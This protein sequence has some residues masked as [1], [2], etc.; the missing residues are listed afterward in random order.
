MR[1]RARPAFTLIELLVV[2]VI[3]A[4]LIGLLL[5]AV[6]KVRD[7]AARASCQN[8]LKQL[9]LAMHNYHDAAGT[10]PTGGD[11]KPTPTKYL[12][13]WVPLLMPFIEDDN[14]RKAIDAMGS[15]ADLQPWRSQIV[16]VMTSPVF[17]TP[18]KTLVC[19]S[20]ELIASSDSFPDD[21]VA[22]PTNHLN[23]SPLH[24]RANGGSATLG[25]QYATTGRHQWWA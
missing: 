21:V 14:R 5:P 19:P 20:S 12:M 22:P 3:I 24:Y 8:N 7:A 15:C 6:Q 2:I 25:L 17:V 16:S 18:I 13:G 1:A 10:L 4:I 9:A 23:Q 11:R